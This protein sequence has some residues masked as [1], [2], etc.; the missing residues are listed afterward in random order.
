MCSGI[1]CLDIKTRL[2]NI[3]DQAINNLS[4]TYSAL[5]RHQEALEMRES[6]LKY[7][8]HALPENHL[9]L[10]TVFSLLNPF[11]WFKAIY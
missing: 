8:E 1:D 11:L 5:G 4:K 6:V 7:R 2:M 9:G 10:G 3:S